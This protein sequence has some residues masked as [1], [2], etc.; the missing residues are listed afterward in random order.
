MK[1]QNIQNNLRLTYDSIAKDFSDTRRFAWPELSVFIPYLPNSFKVLD[2]GCGNGR[3]LS[4]LKDS[5]KDFDY[6]G[7]DFSEQLINQAKKQW[8][9]YK[10][11]L[12]D[13]QAID[14]PA[15][16]FDC[17]V[18][19]ASFHHLYTKKERVYLLQK[20]NT[21]LKPGGILFMTNWNLGQKKYLSS[22]FNRFWQKKV[23]N[24]CFV[25]YTLASSNKKYWRYYHHF[26][27]RELTN[28][29]K[30]SGF[31]LLDRGVYWSKYNLVALAKKS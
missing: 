10:F 6:L 15:Q 3:L 4:V 23:W 20:I 28:L 11:Q 19:I 9:D 5:A 18:M 16:S 1:G 24:D 8:P 22:W 30:A 31:S 13:M 29:L 2:L 7:V 17:V 14:F 27:K 12:S 26:T 21:I 25:P